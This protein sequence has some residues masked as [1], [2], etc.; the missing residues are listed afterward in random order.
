MIV[1]VWLIYKAGEPRVYTCAYQPAAD[2]A[3]CFKR[4]GF[5]IYRAEISLPVDQ[6]TDFVKGR[7]KVESLDGK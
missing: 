4:D 3:A 7:A 5:T 1:N 6:G 2:Q